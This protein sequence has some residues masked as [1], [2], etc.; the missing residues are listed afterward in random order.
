MA[1][2]SAVLGMLGLNGLPRPHHPVFNV[3]SFALAS[4]NRFFLCL[5]AR[6]PLFDVDSARAGSWK[7]I[8]RGRSPWCRPERRV[9]KVNRDETEG[10]R[11]EDRSPPC[12]RW[13]WLSGLRPCCA[14]RS[15]GLPERDVRSA[16]LQALP[17]QRLFRRRH[18]GPA[19]GRRHR[20]APRS[21]TSGATPPPSTSR[22]ARPAGKLA[23][24]LPFPVDRSVLERG[25]DR[26]RIFCTPCHGEL[27]DGRG[28][29][30]RRGFNPPPTLSQRRDAQE[31]VGHFFDVMTRGHRHHVFLCVA[32]SAQRPLGHRGLHPGAC[33]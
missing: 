13:R 7:S 30:V 3:P 21:Q 32:D 17:C 33:N 12:G 31:P 27:G 28:M 26:Y 6:D 2:L 15:A 18:L 9:Q 20:P 4:R 22:P 14:G 1:A 25:Q 19:A 29:I 23:D 24:T 16:P 10:R 8:A 11:R 5:Q